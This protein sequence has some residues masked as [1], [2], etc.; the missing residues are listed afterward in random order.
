M[1]YIKTD[2]TCRLD[3]LPWTP[4]HTK[5][6]LALG[7]TWILDAFEVVIV[8]VVLKSMAKSLSLSTFESSWLVSSFLVGALVGAF[9]FGYLADK[10]GRK[11]IFFITLF[12]YSIGTFL[13]GFAD[14]FEI[15]ILFRFITGL[16][17]GGEFSAIHSAIDEFI[18]SKYRGRVDGFITASWNLGSVFASLTGMYLLSHLPEEKAWRYA[19]LFGGI[20]ALLI[21]VVRIFIPESPRWLISKGYTQ[22]AEEIVKKLEEKYKIKP[23]KKECDIPIFEGSLKD[24]LKIILKKY[25]GRFLFGMAMSF[26]ILTTYYGFITIL[27]LVITN[28]YNLPTSEIP[29]LLL[30]ASAGGLLGGL[31]V[32]LLTDYLGRKITGTVIALLSMLL[33]VT[34][35]FSYDIYSTVFVY[36]FVAYSFA[37]VAYVS[38]MEVYPSYLRATAIGVLSVIGRISGVLAPPILTYLSQINYKY[39]IL[40]LT[41]FWFVGFTAFFLWSKFGIE[42]KG[43]SIE[44]IS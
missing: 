21:V 18:P 16:G 7:I 29:K 8:S 28:Q 32:S 39:S 9:I 41:F 23:T 26:T 44:E 14:S 34:F 36:S 24:A 25:R 15:A 2:I 5:F 27:P 12:L 20:L 4:F 43:K 42:A 13:T 19:F 33:S 22:K 40:G 10:Y 3:N 30:Y 35:L 11:K 31:A 1:K 17:L 37:S 6:V 38:A